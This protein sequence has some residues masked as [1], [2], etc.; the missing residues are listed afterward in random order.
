MSAVYI[1]IASFEN[2]VRKLILDVMLEEFGEGWWDQKVS[3]DIQKRAQKKIDDEKQ[4]RW[5]TPRGL[6]PIYFT[7]L[8]DLTSIINAN[9]TA[10][11]DTLADPEWVRHTIRSLERS[12][13]V[14]MHS[15]ELSIADIER[16][17]MTIRD[18]IR[19]VGF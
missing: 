3:S 9:F 8:K 2:S 11:E 12:R 6:S 17:G 19:Q 4:I 13:N 18:W 14:I 16:V 7:E 10:F 5:H 15:G 1:A